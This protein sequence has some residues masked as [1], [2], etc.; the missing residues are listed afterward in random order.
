[1]VS[2][3]D[4]LTRY[5]D[6]L[7]SAIDPEW[8]ARKVR[9]WKRA[10][11]FEPTP[12]GFRVDAV[13][14][15][16]E[17]RGEWPVIR[18]NDAIRDPELM[19]LRE[20]AGVYDAVC[21][22]THVIPNI[23]ANYGTG[24]LPGLFG[25]EPFW[26]EDALDTLP[27]CRPLAGDDPIGRLLDLGEPDLCAGLGARVLETADYFVRTLSP[28]PAI[29]QAVWLYHPDLQGPVDVLELLCGSAMFTA[30]Y[31]RADDVHAALDLVTRTYARFMSHW[32][33][34][35]PERD[36]D[37]TAHWGYFFR[38]HVMLRD[39]SIVNL[40]PAMYAEFV[41]PYDDRLLATFGGGAIHFCGRA[42]HCIDLMT[43]CP[44]LTGVDLSQPHLNDMD[45]VLAATVGKG[46]TL[47]CPATERMRREC[48][49]SRGVTLRPAGR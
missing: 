28:Y 46:I 9:E 38:G 27:A 48:D 8:E 13:E 47:N 17:P 20:L 15:E 44:H 12:G 35:F 7:E 36:P 43:D 30:F 6:R 22:R 31:D 14:G 32:L 49:L 18:V 33:E 19:L 26:M 29:R 37:Y 10:L 39:D 41:K 25:A 3:K 16:P 11:A 34:R 2:V 21:A 1:M 4:E 5:L 40:S 23:R 24:I 42:D 45:R